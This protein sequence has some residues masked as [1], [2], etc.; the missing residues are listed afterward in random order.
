MQDHNPI[1]PG[2]ELNWPKL[3]VYLR[4]ELPDLKGDFYVAQFHGGH[5]NLTYLLRFGDQE[6]VL[7]RP[8]SFQ[9]SLHPR[10]AP[11]YSAPIMMSLVVIL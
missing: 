5:A 7:R 8:P 4:S 2:E 1:R 10:P 6:L 3:E 11:T 9:P